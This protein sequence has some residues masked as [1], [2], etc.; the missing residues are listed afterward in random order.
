M[1][2]G[3]WIVVATLVTACA[4]DRFPEAAS[5]DSQSTYTYPGCASG[6]LLCPQ[7]V[8][9]LC[10]I[11]NLQNAHGACQEDADCTLVTLPSSCYATGDCPPVA[12]ATANEVAFT[13]EATA[14]IEAYCDS[15]RCD[16][17]STCNLDPGLVRAACVEGR[18][19]S[20]VEEGP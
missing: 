2:V 14:E 7:D 9:L 1:R 15:P 10:A 16:G 18:C 4:Q 5:I 19:I 11:H 6:E 3:R 12:V 13:L 20:E 8:T 17:P